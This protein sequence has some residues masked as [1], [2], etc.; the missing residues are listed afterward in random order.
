M[1]ISRDSNYWAVGSLIIKVFVCFVKCP[2]STPVP[3]TSNC[4]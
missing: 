4:N 2:N 3:E 1:T